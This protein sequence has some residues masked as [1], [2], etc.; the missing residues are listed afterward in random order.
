MDATEQKSNKWSYVT[1]ATLAEKAEMQAM[2]DAENE[3]QQQEPH[4]WDENDNDCPI[5]FK[6]ELHSGWQM[7]AYTPSGKI[8]GGFHEGFIRCWNCGGIVTDAGDDEKF[9][10]RCF[11]ELTEYGWH[12]P[13]RSHGVIG[14]H[15]TH[16]RRSNRR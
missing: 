11:A 4:G 13:N 14:H 2:I 6:L 9:C 15:R 8:M 7:T 12:H 10:F 1:R 5:H 3:F 16:G